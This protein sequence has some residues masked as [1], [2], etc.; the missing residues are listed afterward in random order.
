MIVDASVEEISVLQHQS[1]V[2][3]SFPNHYHVCPEL[4]LVQALQAT[5]LLF[6]LRQLDTPFLIRNVLKFLFTGVQLLFTSSITSLV[7]S[8]HYLT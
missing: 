8:T 1:S 7:Y 2:E 6:S 4:P 3:G 5:W